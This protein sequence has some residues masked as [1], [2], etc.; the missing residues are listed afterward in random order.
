MLLS[1]SSSPS[2]NTCCTSRSR[3]CT[4]QAQLNANIFLAPVFNPRQQTPW[5]ILFLIFGVTEP[6]VGIEL[7]VT[8]FSR[9][10]YSL[11]FLSA[12]K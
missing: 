12:S 6:R 1:P 3:S 8:K 2:L 5:L 4:R 7:L 11:I 10:R 9:R